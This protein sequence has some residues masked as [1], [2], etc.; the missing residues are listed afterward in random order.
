M[1][2]KG[3]ISASTGY[4]GYPFEGTTKGRVYCKSN[5]IKGK[6]FTITETAD[7]FEIDKY[8]L[9]PVKTVEQLEPE[10]KPKPKSTSSHNSKKEICK[11][12]GN[13]YPI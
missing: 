6:W 1:E 3:G 5:D 7:L 9:M 11:I 8:D 10:I 4:S 13:C 12:D 2:F